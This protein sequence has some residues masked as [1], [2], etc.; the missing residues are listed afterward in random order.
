MNIQIGQTILYS[1]KYNI[2]KVE[3][4]IEEV[5]NMGYKI[6]GCWYEK[7]EITIEQILLD[8]KTPQNG[9]LILG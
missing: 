3:G 1:T 7:N 6:N 5:T 9:T 2:A 8:S 4:I